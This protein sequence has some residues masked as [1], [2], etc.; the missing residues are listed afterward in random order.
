MTGAAPIEDMAVNRAVLRSD[1]FR[2]DREADWK[3]LEGLVS[4]IEKGRYRRLSDDD[5]IALP[6]LYRTLVSSL[7]VAR[8]SS[9]DAA[10][11]AYLESLSLRAYLAVYGT[12]A[13]FFG[14]ARDF[15]GGGW[16]RAVRSM[17]FDHGIALAAMVIGTLLGYFLVLHNLD[18]FYSFLPGD[19]AQERVPGASRQTL[20]GTIFGDE[21]SRGDGL[22]FFAAYLFSN[23]SRVCILAFA[24]GFAFGVPTVMLLLYNTLGLGALYWLFADAGLGV[25]LLGWLSVHGT[26]E[27]FA[28]LLSGGAGI[29]IGRAI[30]FPGQASV[31]AAASAAG[32]R[33]A[34]VMLGCIV[35]LL[36]AGLLEGYARQLVQDTALRFA[37]GGTMLV[38]WLAYFGLSGR[39]SG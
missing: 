13:G 26:T 31:L 3:R 8:E 11:I 23:N 2:Q 32:K 35:M 30:A 27:L 4:Q 33:S 7:S 18:W 20:A 39:K 36:V 21:Q 16:A 37:V 25:D 24:L 6:T 1:R 28:I 10:T 5:L 22:S 15:F 9:L 19:M 14:W 29:H 34:E 17:L 38:F 12:R